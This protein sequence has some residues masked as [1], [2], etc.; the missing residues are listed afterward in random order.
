M[1]KRVVEAIFGARHAR[2]FKRLQPIV[3]QV[4][5][6]ETRLGALDEAELKGQ[7]AKFRSILAGRTDELRDDVNRLKAAKH[8]CAD[9]LDRDALEAQLIAA[10]NAFRKGVA[11]TLD[12]LLPEA[13][14]Q[15][16]ACR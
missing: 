6:H 7:T 14:D 11:A 4:H 16:G 5:E 1:I 13:F 9:P 2:E 10:E 8:D 15:P 12:D 3:A